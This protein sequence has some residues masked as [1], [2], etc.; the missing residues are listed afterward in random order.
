MVLNFALWCL[1]GLIAGAIAQFL[2]PGRDPGQAA[3]PLSLAIT[4]V[5]GIVGA[6]IGGAVSSRLLGWDVTGFNV[7]SMVVAVGGALV[8][9][10]LYRVLTSGGF[11]PRRSPSRH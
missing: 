7:P 1:F 11:G 8:L 5:L 2:M 10:L 6:A 3:N 9:L 4:I